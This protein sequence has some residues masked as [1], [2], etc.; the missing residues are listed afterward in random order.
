MTQKL[1]KVH[2]LLEP[3][4]R[5][6]SAAASNPYSLNFSAKNNYCFLV[7]GDTFFSG[8]NLP[9]PS[10]FLFILSCV[11]VFVSC[12][13]MVSRPCRAGGY[14]LLLIGV[15]GLE[16]VRKLELRS[17]LMFNMLSAGCFG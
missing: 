17:G 12:I 15:V 7:F 3:G 2:I 13:L 1:W 6:E 16:R 5:Y 10:W 14:I 8:L 9:I 4:S 11:V